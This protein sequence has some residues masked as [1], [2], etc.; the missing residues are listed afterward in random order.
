MGNNRQVL[1]MA[2][3]RKLMKRC[4][5]FYIAMGCVYFK[6]IFEEI[7]KRELVIC[8]YL[9]DEHK[10]IHVFDYGH[11]FLMIIPHDGDTGIDVYLDDELQG[12]SSE[13]QLIMMGDS[14]SPELYIS[15]FERDILVSNENMDVASIKRK[16]VVDKIIS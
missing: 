10:A 12:S 7:S 11:K 1:D 2:E 5:L 3:V 14:Y 15:L 13:I 9:V 6:G 8:T 4:D 16:W